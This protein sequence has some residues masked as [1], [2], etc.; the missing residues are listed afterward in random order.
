MRWL[1]LIFFLALR[2]MSYAV[3]T[4]HVITHNQL[5]VVTDPSKGSNF[6]SRWGVF[7][8]AGKPIRRIN[9][10]V[11]FKCPDTMRCADWDYLDFIKIKRIGGMQGA[12]KDFE[13]AR[14]LTPY[15]GAFN[16]DWNFNW[17]VDITDFS[18]L[19]RDS[20]EIEYNHTGYEDN[21]HRG[22]KITLDFEI[23]T[24]QPIA[25]PI[26]IQKIYSKA[27]GY[28]DS[29][30]SIEKSLVPIAFKKAPGADY[31][32]FRV[33]HTGHGANPGDYCGEF[34]SKKRFT[35]FN[36]DVIDERP[37]WRKC[38]D[39]PLYPQAG[40]WV[41]DRANWCPGYLQQ[42]EVLHIPLTRND[43]T[44]DIDME[45][46]TITKSEAVENITAYLI[47]YKKNTLQHDATIIDII[48]PTNKKIYSRLN[49]TCSMP[50]ILIKNSGTATLKSLQIKYGTVGQA[51]HS[52]TWTGLIKSGYTDT[53]TMPTTIQALANNNTYMVE[54]T[55]PNG[56]FDRFNADNYMVS[57]FK[58]PPLHA[59]SLVLVT[60]TNN[61]PQDNFITLKNSEGQVFL[62]RSFDSTQKNKVFLDT[63]MLPVGCYTL[64]CIDTAGNGL[65][66]W[67]YA[68][69]GKG[70][71]RIQDTAGNLVKS[72]ISD[73]GSSI[74]YNFTTTNNNRDVD[75]LNK[76]LVIDLFPTRSNG[77]T[78][79]DFFSGKPCDV[80][81]KIITDKGAVVV[82][83]H[84]YKNVKDASFTYNLAYRPSQR[85]YVKLFIEGKEV[86]NKRLRIEKR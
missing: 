84:N 48:T 36:E 1:L 10:H 74:L 33:L 85:Y 3:D 57:Q 19:L 32:V 76:E 41:Y 82:E 70:S 62:S 38:G 42:P 51:L 60:K 64:A 72:F 27:F 24:G 28:G 31:A 86:F 71:M 55:K 73:F 45:P 58:K 44:I 4:L 35:I 53:V 23:I 63:L 49:P 29:A 16:K 9:L 37:I 11:T 77:S 26:S 69:G 12:D 81:V 34:C 83:E 14:M 21:K 67:A 8:S 52:F 18:L 13:I 65:E 22:W 59:S 2:Q 79:L 7:P 50:K 68:K 6:Y 56:K 39:N 61:E 75:S 25:Q 15:G 80:T 5:V 78:T 40:T 46:Y 30:Q 66:F 43:N 17:Q 47:Q 20:V 54:L